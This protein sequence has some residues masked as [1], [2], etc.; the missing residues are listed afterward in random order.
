MMNHKL[1]HIHIVIGA[2]PNYMKADP[3][4][5][6]LDASG[7]YRLAL[8]HTGQHY[9]L[10]MSKL[11]FDDLGM[12][13]PHIALEVGSGPHGA[14]T[15][16]VLARYEAV[17]IKNRPDLVIVFGD[18]NSTIAC[19]LAAVKLHIPVAHVEAGLRS[20]DR[21]M[22]EEINRVLTDQISQLLFITSRDARANL[23]REGVDEKRIHFVGNTMIDSLEKFRDRFDDSKIIDQLNLTEPYALI[24]LHRPS[25][26]D[27]REPLEKLVQALFKTTDQLTCVF[28]IHPRTRDK[29]AAFE[30]LPLLKNNRRFRLL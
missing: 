4:Y 28:P 7:K 26:V 24:T 23:I 13:K 30:L 9:D 19:A 29:L 5:K 12:Q 17:L 8:I 21:R 16:K 27:E 18:V 11:F 2:R 6:A 25:N 3:V 1:P 15:A 14:Q 22:P 10:R 20:N